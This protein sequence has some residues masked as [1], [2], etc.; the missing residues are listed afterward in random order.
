MK[1]ITLMI[2]AFI[3][4]ITAFAQNVKFLPDKPEAGKALNFEYNTK[5]TKLEGLANVTCIAQTFVN[6][7]YKKVDIKLEKEGSV[8]RGS[9]VPVDSTSI[10]VLVFSADGTKDE[11]PAGYYTLFYQNGKPTA[12]SY[13][14]QAQFYSGLGKSLSGAETDKEKAI[15]AYES[16]FAEDTKL[17]ETYYVNYLGLVNGVDKTKGSSLA[18]AYIKQL[19]QKR[20]ASESDLNKIALVYNALKLKS[21]ADS[22]YNI[23]K[24]KYPHG[25]YMFGQTAN[26]IYRETSAVKKEEKLNE[27]VKNFKL[28]VNNEADYKKLEGLYMELASAFG[29]EKNN[30]KFEDYANKI[31]NKTSL[32]SICNSFAWACAEKNENVVFAT[33]ISKKSLDLLDAAKQDPVPA[34]YNSKEDYLKNLESNW[35]SYADTYALLLNHSGNKAEAL[36]YQK[37]AVK[38]NNFS[39]ADMNSRYVVFLAD[40]NRFKDAR[41]YGERFIKEGKGGAEIKGA[42]KKAYQGNE[43]FDVYYA[44][45]EREALEKEREKFVKEMINRPAPKFTLVNLKGE[46]VSLEKLKGKVVIV[47]YW[48][49]WCGPCIASFPGMQMAV[50]KY[51]D[52]P[53]VE[54]LFVNTWQTEEN[55]EKVV[56]DFM[57]ANS[58]YTF[59]VLLDTKNKQDPSKF[60]VIDSYNLNGDGI[61][62]KYIID[63]NGN[64]RF[65]KVGFGGSADATVKE[66]DVM[67]SLAKETK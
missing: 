67:I 4:G 48:A 15:K 59:N 54:F 40:N 16:A 52:D 38:M 13:Y 24:T 47:D 14:W 55:R 53:K 22:V 49:T 11:N 64:I 17:K 12:M 37:Q 29:Q 62:Q 60:D 31:K 63:P 56:K 3:A 27:L 46:T 57:A 66:L 6:T 65:K 42:L 5:G 32:A 51:K 30:Q 43:G 44:K 7:R 23:I 41:E 33:Q 1:K 2:C 61:P 9:F 50:E 18:H 25:N 19:N 26:V 39:S 21:S 28:N 34:F 8:Y 20:D 35:A 36:K 58:K 45:L 10:A